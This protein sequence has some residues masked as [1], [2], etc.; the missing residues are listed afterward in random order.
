MRSALVNCLLLAVLLTAPTDYEARMLADVRDG[1]LD[2]L[3]L[4]TAAMIAAGPKQPASIASAMLVLKR[5]L[6]PVV[7]ATRAVESSERPRKLLD[8]LHGSLLKR[9][10]SDATT[11]YDIVATGRFNALSASLLYRLA[12]E[13]VGIDAQVVLRGDR[14]L[15]F[16]DETLD[17]TSPQA[18]VDD[19]QDI[20]LDPL[21]LLSLIYA[22]K[23]TMAEDPSFLLKKAALLDKSKLAPEY[24]VSVLLQ[25]NNSRRALAID[26]VDAL[27]LKIVDRQKNDASEVEAW[28]ARLEPFNNIRY[29]ALAKLYLKANDLSGAA[30]AI[31]LGRKTCSDCSA[32][33]LLDK[34]RL[35]KWSESDGVGA[36]E[37]FLASYPQE[38]A[39]S[40]IATNHVQALLSERRCSDAQAAAERWQA[41][42][43]DSI[44]AC[45]VQ[46]GEA[47]MREKRFDVAAVEL[48]TAVNA[49]AQV[50]KTLLGA[51]T[52]Q[53]LEL[54]KQK[55]CRDAR[56]W[57]EEG[58]RLDPNDAFFSEGLAYCAR[59]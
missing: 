9:F 33:V 54:I 53:A 56:E 51:V 37:A 3:P 40:V 35:S 32:L 24:A 20:E 49:G 21:T 25:G 45:F 50:Q 44:E 2:Q 27:V 6:K 48:R 15:I 47:L 26:D 1:Q 17:P 41:D 30:F 58:R 59:R 29:Q 43:A 34:E 16:A 28:G 38:D 52:Q 22:H 7:E 23:A 5:K 4:E 13:R 31:D 19:A 10:S 57:L 39:P 46:K 55:R 36:A 18:R 12:A 14:V 11:L 8:L 42:Q